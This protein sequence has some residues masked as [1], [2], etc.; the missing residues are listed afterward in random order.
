MSYFYSYTSLLPA[1]LPLLPALLILF[2]T[3]LSLFPAWLP[4]FP[5]RN[6]L[7]P[8]WLLLFPAR[9]PLFPEHI[10]R[11]QITDQSQHRSYPKT[12]L[13]QAPSTEI[14]NTT[15]QIARL[16]GLKSIG[17]LE[18]APIP[19][20][21]ISVW[22]IHDTSTVR[23]QETAQ[24]NPKKWTQLSNFSAPEVKHTE[25]KPCASHQFQIWSKMY[26]TRGGWCFK[27]SCETLIKQSVANMC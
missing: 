1:L 27:G 19:W 16:K 9:V 15:Q 11:K 3:W 18:G 23:I 5:A 4:F 21:P 7:I 6:V 24:H 20:I 17:P 10:W 13:F 8:A 14:Q 26:E 12:F 25:Q 22:Q 2:P